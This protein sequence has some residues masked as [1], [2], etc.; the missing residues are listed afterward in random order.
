M[1]LRR[2]PFTTSY[3]D[4]LSRVN[5]L[6]NPDFVP[7]GVTVIYDRAQLPGTVM[8]AIRRFV[9]EAQAELK[10]FESARDAIFKDA[11]WDPR[12]EESPP[13]GVEERFNELL[14]EEVTFDVTT[15]PEEEFVGCGLS[16]RELDI[17][18]PIINTDEPDAA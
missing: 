14:A 13:A 11:G 4:L 18:N 1:S 3:G 10:D 8:L 16:L 9:R 15:I 12:G 5:L 7:E 2:Q 6:R 17:L